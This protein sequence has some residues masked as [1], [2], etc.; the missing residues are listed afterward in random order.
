DQ[1]IPMIKAAAEA[2]AHILME[3]PFA[4]NLA[5]ADAMIAILDR[6]GV[7]VQVGH[8]ARALA[9]TEET[10]KRLRAGEFGELLEIRARGK[11]DRRAGGEDLIVLGSH[12]FDL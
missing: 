8:T 1:R 11:E 9:V 6:A 7:K 3:K 4:S 2:R 10:R 12:C 5:E